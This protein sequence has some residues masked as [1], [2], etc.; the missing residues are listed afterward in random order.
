[1][2]SKEKGLHFELVSG[3]L[4]FAP[5]KRC[6]L[7]KEIETVPPKSGRIVSI[8]S[9]DYKPDYKRDQKESSS[10]FNLFMAHRL[11]TPDLEFCVLAQDI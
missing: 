9:L 1:M 7:K 5:K 11:R 6:S 10:L 8:P 3:F 2:F 4:L